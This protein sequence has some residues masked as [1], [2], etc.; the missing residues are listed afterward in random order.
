MGKPFSWDQTKLVLLLYKSDVVLIIF[1]TSEKKYLT[2][3]AKRKN[4]LRSQFVELSAQN[5]LALRQGSGRRATIQ[6]MEDTKSNKRGRESKPLSVPYMTSYLH[7]IHIL[8]P[9]TDH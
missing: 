4:L 2:P 9:T 8:N 5:Q 6:G 7:S 1:L 3:K